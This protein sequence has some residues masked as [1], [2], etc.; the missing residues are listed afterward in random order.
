MKE[1]IQ[2]NK[3]EIVIPENWNYE[4]SVKKVKVLVYKWKNLTTE[5]I[6]ELWTAHEIIDG[7]GRP[8]IIDKISLNG[9]KCYSFSQYCQ[10]CGITKMTA[11]RW[12]RR[13]GLIEKPQQIQSPDLPE[14]KYFVFYGDPPWQFDNSGFTES[15]EQKY[16]TMPVESICD[17]PIKDL[18]DKKAVLFLWVTNAFLREGLQVCEAWGFE[19]K[20]NLV[21]IK[22]TGPSIGWFSQSRHE[23]LF[24]ATKGDGVHPTEKMISWFEAEVTQHSKKPERVYEM[25]ETMYS[26]PYIE[27][28]ARNKRKGWDSW[29]NE[30]PKD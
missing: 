1:I 15:A 16:P 8:K 5:L 9:N 3:N 19:Y 20:T 18:I 11:W 26:G 12:L 23:L 21:W 14:G 27:L 13:V 25:I 6:T 28:F 7:R 24:I 30:L 2:L 17:L 22:N 10:D 29:G 4:D